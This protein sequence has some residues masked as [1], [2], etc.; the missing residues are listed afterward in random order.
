M[1][2]RYPPRHAEDWIARVLKSPGSHHGVI[3]DLRE[4]YA[5]RLRRQPRLVC[6]LWFWQQAVAVFWSFG[7]EARHAR[8]RTARR[9]GEMINRLLQD[10]RFAWRGIRKN[11]GFALPVIL[12]LS[13]GIGSST[14]IFSVLDAVV[15]APLPYP[16]P[17][18][19]V[20]VWEIETSAGQDPEGGEATSD[21]RAIRPEQQISPVNFGDYRALEHVFED[22]TAWWYPDIALTDDNNDPLRANTIEVTT[23]FFRVMGIGP[24]VGGGFTEVEHPFTSESEVVISHRVWKSRFSADPGLIGQTVR[25]NGNPF[26]VTAVMPDGF[27]YPDDTDIWMGLAWDPEKHSRAAHFMDSLGRL[28]PGVT[29]EQAQVEL[30]ALTGRLAMEFPATNGE[31]GVRIVSLHEEV[32]GFFRLALFALLGAVGLLMVIACINVANLMLARLTVRGR[33]AA[34]RTAIGATRGRLLGQL[35]TESVLLAVLGGMAGLLLAFGGIRLLLAGS[36]IDIPRFDQ[37]VMDLRVLGFAFGVATITAFLVGLVPAA[38]YSRTDIGQM[39]KQNNRVFALGAGRARSSLV[40]IEVSLAVMMLVESGL[41]IRTVSLLVRQDAGFEEQNVLTAN[42]QLS[43]TSYPDWPDVER[44][45]SDLIRSLQTHPLVSDAG[46]GNFLPL[47]SG[48][49]NSFGIPGRPA[50]R[51]GERPQAQY[52]TVT[53]GYFE[54]MGI[55]LINGRFFD[56]RD[57][58]GSPGVIVV[59]EAFAR[60]HFDGESPVGRLIAADWRG[61]GILGRSVVDERDHRIVGVVGDVRNQSLRQATEP[62]IY[63]TGRQFPFRNMHLVLGGMHDAAGLIPVLKAVLRETD[64]SLPLENIRTMES[65]MAIP[66][67]QPRFLMFLLSGFASI[68]LALSSVGVYGVLSYSVTQRRPE[69]SIRMALGAAP[70]SVRW[71]VVRGGMRLVV[72]GVLVGGVGANLTSRFLSSVVYGVGVTDL[73]TYTGVIVLVVG[74]A[75][76]ACVLPAYAASRIDPLAGLRI[77]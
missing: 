74:V 13:L 3:G 51:D 63:F 25:L 55:P 10:V 39:L 52:H 28:A 54:T 8:Y 66:I 6:D 15:L 29:I 40:V 75:L 2:S 59:N 20:M 34:I 31:R 43:S 48:W 77:E 36:P 11:P 46:A 49:R 73:P 47:Q 65:V 35:L 42:L 4:E 12:T 38:L 30:D 17:D 37:V 24:A 57:G 22:I 14:A 61:I 1:L 69:I 50:D 26:T 23:N 32:V 71:F 21:G 68:A 64:P 45:Y 7:R 41:L 60:L 76:V 56:E 16:E 53:E 44:L 62:A 70:A 18:R 72:L 67:Q 27:H 5:D 58:A 33:E 9:K 19:L